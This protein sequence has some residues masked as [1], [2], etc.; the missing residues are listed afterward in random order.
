MSG[1]IPVIWELV[2]FI[3]YQYYTLILGRNANPDIIPSTCCPIVAGLLISSSYI[4]AVPKE[5]V[6]ST[7]MLYKGAKEMVHSPDSDTN[8]FDIVAR[9][10]QKI[11]SISIFNLPRLVPFLLLIYLDYILRM[12]IDLM[13]KKTLCAKKH[14][15]LRISSR[16]YFWSDSADDL[17]LLANTHAQAE[18]LLH[19]LEQAERGIGLYMKSDNQVQV[20]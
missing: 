20:F 6:T 4:F 7:M 1:T 8:S 14:K 2:Y 18:S 10:L 17:V 5:T 13:E 9:V 19:S 3:D 16:N 11:G 12:V 15:E